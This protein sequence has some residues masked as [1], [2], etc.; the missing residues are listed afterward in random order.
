MPQNDVE[1]SSDPAAPVQ[2]SSKAADGPVV[3]AAA[4]SKT[5]SA[6]MDVSEMKK[7]SEECKR[8]QAEMGK[9]TEENRQLKVRL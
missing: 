6:S 5:V 8:L 2:N 4:A 9:L 7:L 1:G 3:K